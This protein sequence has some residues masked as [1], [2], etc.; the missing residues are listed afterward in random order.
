M[1]TAILRLGIDDRFSEFNGSWDY[2]RREH[3]IDADS[4]RDAM[5]QQHASDL[6]VRLELV[7]P[8]PLALQ[9]HKDLQALH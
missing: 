8:V 9:A 6:R 3:G 1:L 7:L 4:L 5:R 2:L